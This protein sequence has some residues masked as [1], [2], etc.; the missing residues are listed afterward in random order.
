VD[1]GGVVLYGLANAIPQLHMRG[2]PEDVIVKLNCDFV[3]ERQAPSTPSAT[4][5]T[6]YWRALGGLCRALSDA[7]HPEIPPDH[8]R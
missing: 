4:A 5:P 6:G 8:G 1:L 7:I 2:L 3:E